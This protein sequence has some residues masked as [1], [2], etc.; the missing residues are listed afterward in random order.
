MDVKLKKLIQIV[1]GGRRCGGDRR[2]YSYSLHFPERRRGNERRGIVDR[3][4]TSRIKI[5]RIRCFRNGNASPEA[6]VFHHFLRE[7]DEDKKPT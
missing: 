6:I 1:N 4:K 5:V 3:R 2:N 7:S